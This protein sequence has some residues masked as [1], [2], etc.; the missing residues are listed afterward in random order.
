VLA[1]PAVK[2]I[3]RAFRSATAL[4]AAVWAL[5]ALTV[6]QHVGEDPGRRSCRSPSQLCQTEAINEGRQELS[7]AI[8]TL[9]ADMN[10]L[11]LLGPI[12]SLFLISGSLSG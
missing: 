2:P 10:Q 12:H 11:R 3:A 6:A 7:D 5:S 9:A 8:A 4:P 1:D